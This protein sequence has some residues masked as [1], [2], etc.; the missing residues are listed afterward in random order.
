MSTNEDEINDQLDALEE[1]IK[2]EEIDDKEIKE[3]E[4]PPGF[5]THDEWI[6]AGKDPA[7][8]RGENAYKSQYEALKEVREL[9]STMNHVV[10]GMETWK[11]QQN[12]IKVG[13]IEEA[14]TQAIADL[15]IAKKDDDLDGALAATD[16]I[17][18]LD[19][20]STVVQ[21][22]DVSPVVTDFAGKNP[23]LD[24]K[25]AQFDQEFFHDVQMMH[26]GTLD[27]ILGGDRSAESQ[28]R[29]TPSQIER[30][31]NLAFNK[32]KELHA[33][34]FVS[35]KNNRQTT[36]NPAKRTTTKVDVTTQLKSV[37]GNLKN[38]RDTSPATD[39]HEYLK[40]IDPAVAETFAKNLIGE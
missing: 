33:D 2:P 13:E 18:E 11:Q 12:E 4:K 15:A 8:F 27:S 6:A 26:N 21:T 16:K 40:G 34:K 17:N 37:T 23:I 1:E 31:L 19:K 30:S 25:S 35:S 5:L 32:A 24:E 10:D 3:V 22:I 36:T 20:R 28:K 38:P 7:D 39:L 9:K 14:K 29:L